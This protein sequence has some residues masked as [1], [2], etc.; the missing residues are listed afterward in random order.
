MKNVTFY[1]FDV[2]P[3]NNLRVDQLLAS[4]LP[5][6]SR[7]RIKNWIN[8][9]KI[10]INGKTCSPK[11]KLTT[12]SL[13][14]I[15]IKPNEELD[16]ISSNCF[17]F[18][19]ITDFPF[20]EFNQDKQK[21][22]L[23]DSDSK[24]IMGGVKDVMAGFGFGS[25]KLD[26]AQDVVSFLKTYNKNINR[27]GLLGK[28]MGTKILDVDLTSTKLTKGKDKKTVKKRSKSTVNLDRGDG[29]LS[30]KIDRLTKGAKTIEEFQKP[31]GE[32]DNVYTGILDGK[33]DRVFGEGITQAQKEIQRQNLADRLINFDPAK[34][35]ELSKWLYG[36]SGKAGN[37]VYAGLV[38]KKKL[39]EAGEKR[40]IETSIN[41]E[42]AKQLEAT[43]TSTTEIEDKTKPRNLKDFDIY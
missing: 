23:K 33:F 8:D 40:K 42:E 29:E 37:V 25:I 3:K 14:E 31:G 13:I 22:D 39:F 27:K 11:D 19:W 35:P 34:T 28:L 5:E 18:C 30:E 36:G 20:Y 6:Y 24:G 38:A 16:I 26:N 10:L 21:I 41:T 32:F 12:K 7:S 1:K 43:P 9:E 4:Y 2:E 15:E 17:E